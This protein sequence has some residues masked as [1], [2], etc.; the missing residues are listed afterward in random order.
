MHYLPR[1]RSQGLL[2]ACLAGW[3]S[4]APAWAGDLAWTQDRTSAGLQSAD[5]AVVV[6]YQP[7]R[8]NPPLPAGA[9]IT[10]V[11]A[12]RNY[13]SPAQVRTQVCW[14]SEQ[15]PCVP[16][17]GTQLDTRAFDGRPASG[18][19]LLVHR[20]VR[21]GSGT[22]PLFVRGTVTVWYAVVPALR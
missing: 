2:A 21:W 18:P 17:N 9:R 10:R 6:V 7:G 22:P 20:V 16:L 13:D 4:C 1:A 3:L 19:M 15:G 12:S 5:R 14:A 8:G 11:H